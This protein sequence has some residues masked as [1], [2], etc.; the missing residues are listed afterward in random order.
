MVASPFRG[1]ARTSI[2]ASGRHVYLDMSAVIPGFSGTD[3]L[4]GDG[5]ISVDGGLTSLAIDFSASQTIVD[6]TSGGQAHIDTQQI[7][8]PGTDYLEFPG[9]ANAFQVLHELAQDLRNNRDLSNADYAA[10]L[11]RRIGDLSEMADHIL[12]T[13]GRQSASLQSLE[14]LEYRIGDLEL[15]VET[16]LS[17]VQ[18]TDIPET[19]LRLQNEQSLLEFT[20]SVTAQIT[21]TSLLNFLR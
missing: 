16:Q 7:T 2:D 8:R 18:S 15:E 4:T 11:D 19:V 13:M 10:A 1:P 5:T 6:S 9:T 14:E 20:Y 12:I 3:G 17:N 21:S